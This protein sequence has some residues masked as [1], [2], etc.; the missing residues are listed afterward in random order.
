MRA[1]PRL[2]EGNFLGGRE[3]I[4]GGAHGH[5]HGE[6]GL[7]ATALVRFP[8]CAFPLKAPGALRISAPRRGAAVL[9]RVLT[10]LARRFS[11]PSPIRR[12]APDAS[13]CERNNH[14]RQGGRHPG[15]REGMKA[16]EEA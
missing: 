3:V 5:L 12:T 10:T 13:R 4:N 16:A 9:P 8:S 11:L 6:S 15:G 2:V 7:D 1:S 14:R